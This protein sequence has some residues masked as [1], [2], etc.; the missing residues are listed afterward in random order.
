MTSSDK[1]SEEKVQDGGYGGGVGECQS[2]QG[3]PP[4]QRQ[5]TFSPL[6]NLSHKCPLT[7]AQEE[8][9]TPPPHA[10]PGQTN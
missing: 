2:R 7:L 10:T 1:C 5:V 9:F 4:C 8:K 6:L 3:N